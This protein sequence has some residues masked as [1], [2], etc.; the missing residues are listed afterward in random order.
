M[1]GSKGAAAFVAPA[2]GLIGVFLI[3]PALW[4]LYLGL[5]NLRLLGLAAAQ[6]RFVGLDNF[7]RAVTDPLFANSLRVTL[8]F[9]LGSAVIGQMGLGFTLAWLLRDWRSWGRQVLEVL[10][11][12]AWIIPGSVV[13]FLWIA[14]LDGRTGTLNSVVPFF[15]QNEW[16]LRQPLGSI[17]VFN[18]WRGTAFS[19]LLFGAA[20]NAVPPSHL[21]T[22]RL[23]G[24][25]A[26][27]QLRDVVLPTIRGHIL[28]TLLLVSLWTFNLFTP[29]LLTQGGPNFRTEV[30]PIF[31]FREALRSGQ[32]GYGAAI[33]AI[34][35]LINLAIALFYL[36]ILRE[37]SS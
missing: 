23:A 10:V 18:T 32:F 13:A 37:R 5:T 3:F 12:L 26:W 11:I 15:G 9:V 22:A 19:M 25:S 28:T 1:L 17:I 2:L 14:F 29:F 24:A 16:L 33:S 27:Q 6:P 36:R 20:L 30:L 7:A 34:M 21:E 31:I 35:L 8:A 4:T